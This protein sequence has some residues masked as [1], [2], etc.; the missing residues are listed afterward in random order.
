[1][2]ELKEP[3]VQFVGSHRVR[4][5]KIFDFALC[6]FDNILMILTFAQSLSIFYKG[7]C[8]FFRRFLKIV[9]F[10]CESKLDAAGSG[11]KFTIYKLR[12][13]PKIFGPPPP[14]DVKSR[15]SARATVPDAN[16]WSK[17][18]RTLI[19]SSVLR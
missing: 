3:K 6:L 9:F 15:E 1:M 4:F 13:W 19:I 2:F 17:G 11:N 16:S 5:I 18:L 14:R 7:G 8:D 12:P 10:Q